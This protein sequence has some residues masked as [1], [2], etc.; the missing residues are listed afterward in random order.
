MQNCPNDWVCKSCHESG[1]KM[2]DC[3]KDFSENENVHENEINDEHT[4]SKVPSTQ[5]PIQNDVS[6]N[7]VKMKN[8]SKSDKDGQTMKSITKNVKI[9]D[10]DVQEK[11][12]KS[13]HLQIRPDL[14]ARTPPTPPERLHD[15]N[16][17]NRMLYFY[18]ILCASCGNE[19]I[20]SVVTRCYVMIYADRKSVNSMYKQ[21]I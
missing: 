8:T 10:S 21:L 20:L 4:Q 5:T 1:H 15:R 3:K 7:T 9:V 11:K 12:T 2:M 6:D 19:A 16:S 13:Q 17:H 18:I 14:K